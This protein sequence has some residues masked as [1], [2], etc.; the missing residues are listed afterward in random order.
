MAHIDT[1]Q[2]PRYD[3]PYSGAG[4]DD[5]LGVYVA[6]TLA[7]LYPRWFDVLLTDYEESLQST[8]RYF[9]PSHCYRWI[10]ELDREGEDFVE[11]GTASPDMI[12]AMLAFGFTY[13]RGSYSDICD[14]KYFHT[15]KVN[16]G[17]GTYSGHSVNSG[18]RPEVLYRQ[19]SR[20]LEF[21]QY[22]ADRVFP[23]ICRGMW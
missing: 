5:R 12:G 17:M 21:T 2:A 20:L 9:V 14:M 13:G 7:G 18:Y 16:I 15:S 11:Y 1:V 22:N 10:A 8:A 6:H 4:F 23:H 3:N 19:L